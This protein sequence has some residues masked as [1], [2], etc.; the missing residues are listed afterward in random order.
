M[1]LIHNDFEHKINT[2]VIH[3]EIASRVSLHKGLPLHVLVNIA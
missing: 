1:K 3:N 2:Y